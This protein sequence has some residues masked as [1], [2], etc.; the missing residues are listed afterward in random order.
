MVVVV[1][2]TERSWAFEAVVALVV[3]LTGRLKT[4]VDWDPDSDDGLVEE[5]VKFEKIESFFGSL[6]L[7]DGF[8]LSAIVSGFGRE[9]LGSEENVKPSKENFPPALPSLFDKFSSNASADI[10]IAVGDEESDVLNKDIE[11]L[12]PGFTGFIVTLELG[13]KVVDALPVENVT[14][15]EGDEAMLEVIPNGNTGFETGVPNVS[16]VL[17]L[18]WSPPRNVKPM[19][20][21]GE[22]VEVWTPN[23]NAAG[24]KNIASW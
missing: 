2:V 17:A 5:N 22:L 1:L 4:K 16:P 24:K 14:L 8:L 7:S 13:P 23:L 21:G 12:D 9:N 10:T 15:T 18:D 3:V 19:V 11:G 6:V 20:V